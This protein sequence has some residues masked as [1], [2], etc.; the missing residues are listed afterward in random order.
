MVRD[1]NEED[2]CTFLE[3]KYQMDPSLCKKLG[4]SLKGASLSSLLMLGDMVENRN[5]LN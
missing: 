5:N 3:S 4:L 2:I 1:L